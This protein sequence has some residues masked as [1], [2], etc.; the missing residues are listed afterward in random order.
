MAVWRCNA[1]MAQEGMTMDGR[2]TTVG[3]R[4]KVS[5]Q[6]QAMT[7]KPMKDEGGG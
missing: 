2:A 5:G 6:G 3:R 4:L 1:A 7:M